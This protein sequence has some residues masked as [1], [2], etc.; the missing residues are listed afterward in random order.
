MIAFYL[1][2]GGT[3]LIGL[4]LG[5]SFRVPALIAGTACFVIVA[6]WACLLAGLS[7]SSAT[8]ITLCGLSALQGFYLVGVFT[9][10]V[11]LGRFA[12]RYPS[13]VSGPGQDRGQPPNARY[14]LSL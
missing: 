7:V 13:K 4:Y 9:S 2:I 14:A 12:K 11:V 1:M 3:A 10:Y 8:I 5:I 6:S